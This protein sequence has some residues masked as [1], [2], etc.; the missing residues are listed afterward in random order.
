MAKL[1]RHRGDARD[2]LLQLRV[3]AEKLT[4][5]G[6]APRQITV[7]KSNSVE[8]RLTV[9]FTEPGRSCQHVLATDSNVVVDVAACS[10]S[11]GQQAHDIVKQITDKIS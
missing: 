2:R 8:G 11:G 3:A 1:R 4:A 5:N 6:Q 7:G 9:T 10:F